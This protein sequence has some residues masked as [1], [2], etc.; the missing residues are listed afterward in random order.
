MMY[1]E[2]AIGLICFT[3]GVVFGY[4]P[5]KAKLEEY[6]VE[7][8]VKLNEFERKH[9][10][11]EQSLSIQKDQVIDELFK[12]LET[13]D[14]LQYDIRDTVSRMH[15]TIRSSDSRGASENDSC[16]PYRESIRQCKELLGE[17]ADLLEEGSRLLND[18]ALKHDSLSSIVNS[19]Q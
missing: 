15:N 17:G 4:Y 1:K 14:S 5:S 7:Q 9:R 12:K 16:E 3:V 10:D 13:K 18:N 6:K 11:I 8:Q 19:K 2:I